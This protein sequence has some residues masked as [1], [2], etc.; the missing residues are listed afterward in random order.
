MG[1]RGRKNSY[2]NVILPKKEKIRELL[3]QGY[4]EKD[5]AAKIG[6]SYAT[7]KKYKKQISAFSTL[8]LTEREKNI[9]ALEKSMYMQAI[10]FKQK[11]Q[12][13]MKVRCIEYDEK[14]GKKKREEEKIELYTE[15]IYIPPSQAAAAFLLKNWNKE[16]YANDPALLAVKREELKIKQK[17]AED[18]W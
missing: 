12:K 11:L 10:G 6:V 13:A 5:V 1:K 18:D 7:W 17:K 14:T 8:I 2:D 9:K 16:N 15:E 4:A 3:S